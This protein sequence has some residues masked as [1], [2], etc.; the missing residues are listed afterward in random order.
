MRPALRWW[1]WT[2]I[3]KPL[4]GG[5]FRFVSV[6]QAG[7]HGKGHSL[8]VAVFLGGCGFSC[9]EHQQESNTALSFHDFSRAGHHHCQDGS[10]LASRAGQRKIPAR[11]LWDCHGHR[12]IRE[13]HAFSGEGHVVAKQCGSPSTGGGD[14]FE[15]AFGSKTGKLPPVHAQ[16]QKRPV[17]LLGPL[18]G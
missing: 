4:S 18:S 13:R 14:S 7:F 16:P 3:Q 8:S 6:W 9:D 10:R 12:G 15:H 2:R 11:Y 5:C 17:V 1:V